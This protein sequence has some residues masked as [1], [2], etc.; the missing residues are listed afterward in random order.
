MIH[1]LVLSNSIV[2]P[3]DWSEPG[4]PADMTAQTGLQRRH[5]SSGGLGCSSHPFTPP[6]RSCDTAQPAACPCSL[7]FPD[8]AQLLLTCHQSPPIG[9][10]LSVR[11]NHAQSPLP[12]RIVTLR[13]RSFL[14]GRFSRRRPVA[15]PPPQGT[16]RIQRRSRPA[17]TSSA[18]TALVRDRRG[19][20]LC[21]R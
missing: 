14:G 1:L 7:A 20:W 10:G 15:A 18:A 9:T 2:Q 11:R 13:R 5:D 6:T 21:K 3:A 16:A 8:H 12:G 4:Q 17:Y 19:K